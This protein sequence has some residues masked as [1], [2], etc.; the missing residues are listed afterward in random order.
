MR[1]GED[2]CGYNW[3]KVGGERIRRIKA[4]IICVVRG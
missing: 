2:G 1:A 4:G 3:R